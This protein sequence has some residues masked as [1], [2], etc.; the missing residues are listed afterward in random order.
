MESQEVTGLVTKDEPGLL[1]Q[2]KIAMPFD[3]KTGAMN[4][5]LLTKDK[6]E[7]LK[8]GNSSDES[9]AFGISVGVFLALG[10]IL[11]P[12]YVSGT[13]MGRLIPFLWAMTL[14]SLGASIYLGRK[15]SALRRKRKR[16]FAEILENSVSVAL[17]PTQE[18]T[19]LPPS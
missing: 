1:V 2:A 11:V 4:M 13:A 6:V 19:Q 9:T 17:V 16:E 5:F 3:I 12:L 15:W 7:N 18:T 8:A 10:G 14:T